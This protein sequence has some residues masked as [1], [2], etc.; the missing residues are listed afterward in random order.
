MIS[1]DII[2]EFTIDQIT[3]GGTDPVSN[4]KNAIAIRFYGERARIVILE[5]R[6]AIRANREAT[7]RK[8]QHSTSRRALRNRHYDSAAIR[9][10]YVRG[11][12]FF[13]EYK[14]LQTNPA[15]LE[16]GRWHRVNGVFV[17]GKK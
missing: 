14:W 12:R 8:W 10:K 13:N 11:D 3:S 4:R 5:K 1:N 7:A 6:A 2:D 17:S 15:Y 16:H 9:E